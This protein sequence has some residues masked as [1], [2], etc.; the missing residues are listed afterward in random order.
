MRSLLVLFSYHHHNT[1]KVAKVFAEVLGAQIRTP[2]QTDPGELQQYDLIGLGSGI[3][4]GEH[5]Q[6][7]LDLVDRLPQVFDKKAFLFST[8]YDRRID[9]VHSSLRKRL[10]SK[11]Y[12]IV[13]EFNCGG[14]NTH[15]FLKLFGGLNKGRPNPEDLKR[16]EEFAQ[17]LKLKMQTP[18]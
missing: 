18:P 12:I 6:D 9:L 10:E 3:Y 1:E 7:L 5:H 11:G 16:A 8:S 15:S 4:G 13:D 14:F 17:G 2:E